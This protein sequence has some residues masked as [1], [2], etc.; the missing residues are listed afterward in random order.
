MKDNLVQ[1]LITKDKLLVRAM[2]APEWSSHKSLND[3][4]VW[5]TEVELAKNEGLY[6]VSTTLLVLGEKIPTYKNMG[7]LINSDLVDV[8]HIAEMDSGSKGNV[9]DGSF[10]ANE[11][12]I[13]NLSELAGKTRSEH[14]KYMN[15]VNI[16]LNSE[17]AYIGLFVNKAKSERP[18]A[19]ILLAQEYYKQ[20]TGKVLP[21]Y[22]YDSDSGSLTP[23]NPSEKEK[24][25]FI[26]RMCEER[27]IRSSG[28]GYEVDEGNRQEEKQFDYSDRLK[29]PS[30][31]E[32]IASLREKI[33]NRNLPQEFKAPYKPTQNLSKIDFSTLKMYKDKNING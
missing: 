13:N 28:I 25:E 8:H 21:I 29:T 16:N 27:V 2:D 14:L 7:F 30:A 9:K 5:A 32:C 17:D 1:D 6:S 12:D 11:T 3:F 10:S 22:T 15:E 24:T 18:K 33:S 19:Q 23:F 31:S 20:Q 26:N 4:S